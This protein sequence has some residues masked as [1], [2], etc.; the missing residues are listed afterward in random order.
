MQ[1]ADGLR[2]AGYGQK[3]DHAG[4]FAE[5]LPTRSDH[6]ASRHQRQSYSMHAADPLIDRERYVDQVSK[7]SGSIHAAKT[8]DY[9]RN[10]PS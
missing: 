6:D 5:N 3:Q 7:D 2:D 4:D 1:T 8:R 10:M 9:Q